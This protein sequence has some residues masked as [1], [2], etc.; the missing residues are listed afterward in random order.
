MDVAENRPPEDSILFKYIFAF[1]ALHDY[2]NLI[3]CFL[4]YSIFLTSI[5]MYVN[6]LFDNDHTYPKTINNLHHEFSMT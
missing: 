6:I 4:V 5:I 1:Q 2:F 3:F